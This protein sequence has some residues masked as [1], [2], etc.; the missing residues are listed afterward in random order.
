MR[1]ASR[2]IK[3]M[4]IPSDILLTCT[5]VCMHQD[6]YTFS[7]CLPERTC[8]FQPQEHV[9]RISA[10]AHTCVWGLGRL[11]VCHGAE[12]MRVS[13]AGRAKNDEGGKKHIYKYLQGYPSGCVWRTIPGVTQV[14]EK[15]HEGNTA[16]VTTFNIYVRGNMVK[17]SARQ[18]K[19]LLTTVIHV[20]PYY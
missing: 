19:F 5:W 1:G 15:K 9:P 11:P 4:R 20:E 17:E 10:R 8:H 18:D 3:N 7:E 2:I 6:G 14:D 13:A 12:S 16:V